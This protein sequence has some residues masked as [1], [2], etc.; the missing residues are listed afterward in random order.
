MERPDWIPQLT[1]KHGKHAT[2]EVYRFWF[3][4]HGW[5][6]FYIDEEFG[7]LAIHSDH[8]DWTHT[9]NPA[10]TGKKTLKDFIISANE[11]YL[12]GKL[13][14]GRKDAK[15]WDP[16]ATKKHLI[17]CAKEAGDETRSSLNEAFA[18]STWEWEQGPDLWMHTAPQEAWD[19]FP[20]LY[21]YAI[22]EETSGVQYLRHA[23]LPFFRQWLK[24]NKPKGWVSQ[25]FE[26]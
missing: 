11:D 18:M 16:D 17:Q 24:D 22:R 8:G 26:F 9:W 21:E 13:T 12:T 4:P 14:M 5:V 15:E 25:V 2:V 7:T 3:K 10:H 23:F 19:A 1:E 20:D 6:F